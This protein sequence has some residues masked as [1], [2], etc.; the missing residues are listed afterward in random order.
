MDAKYLVTSLIAIPIILLVALTVFH[1]LSLYGIP[2]GMESTATN[3]TI[4]TDA[5][6]HYTTYD[7]KQ[8]SVTWVHNTTDSL[9][10]SISGTDAD[11]TNC[12]TVVTY[13]NFDTAK[14]VVPGSNISGSIKASYTKYSGDSWTSYSKVYDQTMSGHKL[15]SQVPYILIAMTIVTVIVGA[16]GV[17]KLI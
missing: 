7:A 1:G 2:S 17:S 5:G 11:K 13:R 15:G 9:C 3:E 12:G 8:D 6:T 4:G 14:I 10:G 16:F